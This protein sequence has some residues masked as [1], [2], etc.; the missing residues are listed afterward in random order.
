MR[1]GERLVRKRINHTLSVDIVTNY[2][3][4]EVNP[5]L[6]GI[7]LPLYFL[8]FNIKYLSKVQPLPGMI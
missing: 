1:N 5:T 2:I 3:N 7:M 8:C 4:I 6:G